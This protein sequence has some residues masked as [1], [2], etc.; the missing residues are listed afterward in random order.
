MVKCRAICVVCRIV[1]KVLL[2]VC[3]LSG[4]RYVK[5]LQNFRRAMILE[6]CRL[7]S[8]NTWYHSVQNVACTDL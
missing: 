6:N 4:L 1:C 3:W 8:V 2:S 7:C 5:Y